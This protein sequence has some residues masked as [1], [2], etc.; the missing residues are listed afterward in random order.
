MPR[1]NVDYSKTVIYKIVCN[2]LTITD[3]YVG[4]TTQFTRRKTEHKYH[5]CTDTS[6]KY[7]IKIYEMIRSN[8]CWE[9]WAMVQIEE[10]PCANG[11][12]ARARERHWYEQLQATLNTQHPNRSQQEKTRANYIKNAER[13]KEY[14]R[15]YTLLHKEAILEKNRQSYKLNRDKILAKNK[16][17][18]YMCECGTECKFYTRMKHFKTLKHQSFVNG[19]KETIV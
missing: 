18:R 8:G 15:N 6:K 1:T 13:C 3:L 5:C 4:S 10:F 11:N 17:K 7:K 19:Q 2:D 16:E 9:N 12:E 14:T